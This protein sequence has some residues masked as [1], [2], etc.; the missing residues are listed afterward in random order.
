MPIGH[1]QNNWGIQHFW[2]TPDFL[3]VNIFLCE[4]EKTLD[5]QIF[6]RI[7]KIMKK[8]RKFQ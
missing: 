4:K 7:D 6:S 8:L 5:L 3:G 1:T 2:G